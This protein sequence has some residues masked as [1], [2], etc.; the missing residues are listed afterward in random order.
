MLNLLVR[1]GLSVTSFSSRKDPIAVGA[2]AASLALILETTVA[3][4]RELY[5]FVRSCA[6]QQKLQWHSLMMTRAEGVTSLVSTVYTEAEDARTPSTP[7]PESE[8]DED[9]WFRHGETMV[10]ES[11]TE[12]GAESQG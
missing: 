3:D 2:T 5:K 12:E 10:V 4:I 1:K 11:D 9:A 8:V 6:A 7:P